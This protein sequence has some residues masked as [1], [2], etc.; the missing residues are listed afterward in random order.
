VEFLRKPLA[1]LALACYLIILVATS[2]WPKPVDGEGILSIITSELLQFTARTPA[3]DWIQY[4]ELEAIGNLLLYIPLG[5]FLVVFAPRTKTLL[6]AL[7]P[8]LVSLLAEGVQRLFLPD[9]YATINDVVYNSLGG[10]LGILIA[11]SIARL[12]KNSK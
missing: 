10:L 12:R 7:V 2:I 9:R 5:I 11:K 4:N 6:L 1:L 8:V 3:L